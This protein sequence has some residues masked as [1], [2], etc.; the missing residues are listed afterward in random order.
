[1]VGIAECVGGGAKEKEEF[2]G[3]RFGSWTGERMGGDIKFEEEEGVSAGRRG[4]APGPPEA[5]W[6]EF[7]AGNEGGGARFE[8]VLCAE[9]REGKLGVEVERVKVG[10]VGV[11]S[12]PPCI[13]GRGC[14]GFG[15]LKGGGGGGIA[16]L[17]SSALL[18][19]GD[20]SFSL[21]KG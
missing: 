10:T 1:L 17:S 3:V 21:V 20:G 12:S 13:V 9:L 16:F 4:G 11:L 18:M 14:L 8:E 19:L 7:G 2:V 15:F 5:R 6:A